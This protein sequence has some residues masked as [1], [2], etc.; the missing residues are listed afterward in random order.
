M[1]LAS[2]KQVES[3]VRTKILQLIQAWAQAFRN[4]PKYKVVQDTY[5]IMKVEVV[6]S[7]TN[8][9]LQPIR[10]T[11]CDIKKQLVSLGTATAMGPDN[12]PAI[13]MKTCAPE[14]VNRLAKLFLLHNVMEGVINSAMKQHLLSDIQFGF[15][16]GYSA[17][18]LIAALVHTLKKELNS[19]GQ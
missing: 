19:R 9:S 2:Q 1:F 18:Y 3:N 5:Q 14:V 11:P 8:T 10:F 7:I 13:V 16:Q 15:C 12:I 17:P 4:E 6:P